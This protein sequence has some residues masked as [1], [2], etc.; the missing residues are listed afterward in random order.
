MHLAGAYST[1][2]LRLLPGVNVF[3]RRYSNTTK[4]RWRV[5]LFSATSGASCYIHVKYF[6]GYCHFLDM[7]SAHDSTIK[8]YNFSAIIFYT[9]ACRRCI[10]LI[11][12]NDPKSFYKLYNL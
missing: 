7:W 6:L 2:R 5:A 9:R 11:H 3:I 1:A 4:Q 10:S 12:P 8:K